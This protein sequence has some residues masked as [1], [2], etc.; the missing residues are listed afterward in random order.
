[1]V[2]LHTR[3]III[4]AYII[5]KFNQTSAVKISHLQ[6]K[7]KKLKASI[8]QDYNLRIKYKKY[9]INAKRYEEC[10]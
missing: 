4:I 3:N 9:I 5:A 10:N 8:K 7:A 6:N 1:M 2:I